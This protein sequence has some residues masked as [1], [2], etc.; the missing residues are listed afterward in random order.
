MEAS[1]GRLPTRLHRVRERDRKLVERKKATAL[2][3]Q[4]SLPCEVYGFDFAAT[5]GPLGER[6]IEAHHIL[7]LAR[8][9]ATT[10]RLA[11]LALVCSNCHRMLHRAKPWIRPAQLQGRLRDR[12]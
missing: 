4:G 11:D 2:A 3:R 6:F 7:P 9:G 12:K 5:Y 1:E 8:A 10:T